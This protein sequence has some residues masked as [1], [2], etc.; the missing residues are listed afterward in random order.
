MEQLDKKL[1]EIRE[2][3]I[4]MG[5]FALNSLERSA[6]AIRTDNLQ[7]LQVAAN[8]ELKYVPYLA[9]AVD[10]N[11]VV[12][13]ALYTPEASNLRELIALL[14]ATHEMVR[15][16]DAARS[17]AVGMKSAME[18]QLDIK[19]LKSFIL[20]LHEVSFRSVELVVRGFKEFDM[21]LYRAVKVEEE[22]SD[23]IYSVVQEEIL[24][25]VCGDETLVPTYIKVISTVK[26]LERAA[27][28]AVN[29]ARL[30]LYAHEGGRFKI[31]D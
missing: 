20:K 8:G 3:M 29:V 13:L 26:K 27:D 25:Q 14:K 15:I 18:S 21:D 9:N 16:G 23:K 30:I 7:E 19:S 11:I 31:N 22:K 6:D 17:F 5:E 10:D 2:D 28:H 4:T 1:M 24:K 12:S